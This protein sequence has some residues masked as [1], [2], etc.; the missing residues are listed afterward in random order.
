MIQKES[1]D[2]TVAAFGSTTTAANF[3]GV[4]AR[5]VKSATDYWDLN[6]GVYRPGEA[7]PVFKRGRVNVICQ[8]GTPATNGKV[9]I[10]TKANASYPAATVG[11][12]EAAADST[13]TVELTNARW[14]GAADANGVAELSILTMINA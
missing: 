2:G 7:V 11:G 14:R 10:R 12:F 8:K 13:N 6:T 9:Y 1:T 4:A 3:A 5:E